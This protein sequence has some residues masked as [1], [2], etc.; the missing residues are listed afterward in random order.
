M[1]DHWTEYA[2]TLKTTLTTHKN[3]IIG[4]IPAAITKWEKDLKDKKITAQQL[5]DIKANFKVY[6]DWSKNYTLKW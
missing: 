1:S 4:K 3:T 5:A 6:Q 2:K